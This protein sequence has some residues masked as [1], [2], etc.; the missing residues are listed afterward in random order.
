MSKTGNK[1]KQQFQTEF[2]WLKKGR[3]VRQEWCRVEHTRW[4]YLTQILETTKCISEYSLEESFSS[5][6]WYYLWTDGLCG[7][8]W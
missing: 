2:H 7:V 6:L 3:S 4:G 8:C 5:V 1:L